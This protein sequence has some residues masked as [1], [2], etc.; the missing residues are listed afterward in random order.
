MTATNF[1]PIPFP[2][3]N[4]LVSLVIDLDF[5]YHKK[6]R[7]GPFDAMALATFLSSCPVIQEFS[8]TICECRKFV[9]PPRDE[10]VVM[11]GVGKLRFNFYYCNNLVV[12]SLFDIV[13]FP[14]CSLDAIGVRLEREG[15]GVRRAVPEN[16]TSCTP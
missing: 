13:R 1:V 10:R 2:G 14:R 16:H 9:A 12:K 15:R 4:S 5:M 3:S 6:E 7:A 11:T 8:L